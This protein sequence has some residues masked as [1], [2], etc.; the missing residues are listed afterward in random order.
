MSFER[1]LN[2]GRLSGTSIG[3]PV[4][5]STPVAQLIGTNGFAD[6]STTGVFHSSLPRVA[7]SATRWPSRRPTKTLPLAYATPRLL[8]SQHAN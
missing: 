2:L 6:I 1:C 7:S 3:R 5:R 4:L 8:T